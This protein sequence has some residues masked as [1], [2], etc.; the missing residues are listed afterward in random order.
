MTVY[1]PS[2]FIVYD[3]YLNTITIIVM[4]ILIVSLSERTLYQHIA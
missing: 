4:H 1:L 2:Y 3:A